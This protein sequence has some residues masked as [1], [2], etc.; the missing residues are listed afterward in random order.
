MPVTALGEPP[1]SQRDYLELP[2]GVITEIAG[3]VAEWA[4]DAY[5]ELD[6]SCWTRSNSNVLVNPMCDVPTPERTQ[7]GGVW[8]HAPDLLRA[9]FRHAA[10][11]PDISLGFRCARPAEP[12]ASAR[13]P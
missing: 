12:S 13:L 2:T 5:Q 4:L 3:N 9:T 8:F 1:R 11:A 6:G 7:R 10:G